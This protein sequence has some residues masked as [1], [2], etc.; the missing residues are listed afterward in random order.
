MNIRTLKRF[1]L[2][3]PGIFDDKQSLDIISNDEQIQPK[4]SSNNLKYLKVKSQS[5][6]KTR[7]LLVDVG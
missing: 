1:S 7:R 6:G 4:T 5:L 3:T 2:I